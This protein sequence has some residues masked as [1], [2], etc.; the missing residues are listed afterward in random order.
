MVMVW[1]RIEKFGGSLK[2]SEGWGPQF[3]KPSNTL[4]RRLK[5]VPFS[6]NL[7]IIPKTFPN[8]STLLENSTTF[9]PTCP[10]LPASFQILWS[11]Q[12]C[13]PNLPKSQ[14]RP[15]HPKTCQTRPKCPIQNP[16]NTTHANPPKS[17]QYGPSHSNGCGWQLAVCWALVA[18]NFYLAQIAAYLAWLATDLATVAVHAG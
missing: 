14:T 12:N 16:P 15:N 9:F 3:S 2:V 18:T 6:L 1:G 17:A 4:Y 11:F 7:L 13:P 5:H 8:L 10:N